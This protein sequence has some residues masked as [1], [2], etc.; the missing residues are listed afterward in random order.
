[1][2]VDSFEKNRQA[3]SHWRGLPGRRL[4][5]AV[6]GPGSSADG[7]RFTETPQRNGH[8]T[9]GAC[10]KT[11]SSMTHL[12]RTFKGALGFLTH[13]FLHGLPTLISSSLLLILFFDVYVMRKDELKR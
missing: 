12:F 10:E 4:A 13:G 1:V 11:E 5:S 2:D 9:R 7:G 6:R 3:A 8:R